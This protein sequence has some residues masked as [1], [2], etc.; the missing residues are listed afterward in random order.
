MA[1]YKSMKRYHRTFM[2]IP[3]LQSEATTVS[4]HGN[5]S[6]PSPLDIKVSFPV[7]QQYK[8]ELQKHIFLLCCH[9]LFSRQFAGV[10]IREFFSCLAPPPHVPTI[11]SNHT[12][13]LCTCLTWSTPERPI[14]LETSTTTTSASAPTTSILSLM[15]SSFSSGVKFTTSLT[16][17][18][19]SS[20]QH[21]HF[22]QISGKTLMPSMLDLYFK[23]THRQCVSFFACFTYK[24][25]VQHQL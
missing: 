5:L 4:Y 17:T 2:C 19:V 25:T 20:P 3:R 22:S 9:S 18:T 16:R 1:F 13:R 8:Q 21:L 6:T 11:S 12:A 14:T 7:V 15:S 24:P 23:Q 10:W